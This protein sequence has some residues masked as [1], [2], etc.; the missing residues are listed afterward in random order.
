MNCRSARRPSVAAIIPAGLAGGLI[1]PVSHAREVDAVPG[2]LH[3]WIVVVAAAAVVFTYAAML[4]WLRRRAAER[5]GTAAK[6]T[7]TF[8]P[9]ELERYSR[10]IMLR[11][12]GGE[13]QRK[14]KQSRIAVIGAGGLGSPALLYLAA[15][16]V[17]N[18]TVIDDDSV[19]LSNLQ[20]QIVHSESGVGQKKT[21][22]AAQT[23]RNLNP[24][25]AVTTVVQRLEPGSEDIL[26]GHDIVLDG[27]DSFETRSLVNRCCAARRI[28]LVS[29][30]ISQWEGQVTVADPASGC[31]C[32][33]CLF[34]VQP[35]PDAAP[36]CAEAGVMA[37]L[38]GIIGSLMAAEAIKIAVGAGRPLKGQLLIYDALWG[39]TRMMKYEPRS[40]CRVCGSGAGA[41]TL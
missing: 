28:P 5:A 34:P 1:S 18:I 33:E 22:S 25:A 24:H 37:A 30:A 20:R 27:S 19:E 39:E 3:L 11:E 12:I 14:L 21:R 32:L 23:I 9:P 15:A 40:G 29:G 35:A 38:P 26:D 6:N 13:G 7:A 31:P 2:G 16:G 4:R 41:A 8:S 10:H 17:G 36:A